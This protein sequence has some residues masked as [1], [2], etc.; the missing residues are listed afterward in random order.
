MQNK[1][2]VLFI[3]IYKILINL[4]FLSLGIIIVTFKCNS[5]RVISFL[6]R[7]RIISFH[8]K[9]PEM[10]FHHINL[11]EFGF[12][13]FLAALILLFSSSEIF[14]SIAMLLKKKWGAIGLFI[15]SC[16]W[17]PIGLFFMSKILVLPKTIGLLIDILI[18]ILLVRIT[19]YEKYFK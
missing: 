5:E 17:I 11:P 2:K 10:L 6:M 16:L 3:G 9:V 8:E 12:T 14:F 1:K 18:V 4:I 7:S 13:C 19:F 15:M